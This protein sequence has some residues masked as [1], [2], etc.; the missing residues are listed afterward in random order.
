MKWRKFWKKK[1]ALIDASVDFDNIKKRREDLVQW[2]TTNDLRADL[3]EI[4]EDAWVNVEAR[5]AV[6]RENKYDAKE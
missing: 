4:V 1:S 6:D 3:E 5:L 2:I